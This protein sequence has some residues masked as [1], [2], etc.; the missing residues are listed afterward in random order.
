MTEVTTLIGASVGSY[1]VTGR[2]QHRNHPADGMTAEVSIGDGAY[3]SIINP[4][5]FEDGGPGWVMRYGDPAGI[6]YAVASLLDSYDYLLSG[7][8]SMTEATRRL[9]L[10]R[11]ARAGLART[12]ADS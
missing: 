5:S 3:M 10:M 9:R 2:L 11:K 6:R 8:I 7:H 1:R 4:Q 12:G